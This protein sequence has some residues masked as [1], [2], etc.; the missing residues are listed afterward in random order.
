M[1]T[2]SHRDEADSVASLAPQVG[3]VQGVIIVSRL[4]PSTDGHE[5]V[6]CGNREGRVP[7]LVCSSSGLAVN[8]NGHRVILASLEWEPTTRRDTTMA[9]DRMAVL[10]TV[11]KAIADGDV[12]FL[13]EGVRVL[14]QAVMEAEVTELTGVP[15]GSATRSTADQPERVPRAALG[16]PG[17]HDRAGDPAGPRRLVLPVPARAPA[18]G[19]AGPPRGRPGGVRPGR[20]HPPGRGP[21]RGPGHRL[22]QQSEVSRICA[23]LDA[24]VE[25]FPAPPAPGREA[26]PYLWPLA[27]KPRAA[28]S[29]HGTQCGSDGDDAVL[30]YREVAPALLMAS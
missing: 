12:D 8:E 26:Y 20:L 5:P 30:D 15:R 2:P 9:E 29:L 13:R 11:R 22:D 24:E 19:R 7:I 17:G 27:T 25:A 1:T 28:Q 18:A 6:S 10:E 23:A 3:Q 21:R 16:H 14:A 4:A